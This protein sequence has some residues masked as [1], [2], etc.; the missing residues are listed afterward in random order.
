MERTGRQTNP[1]SGHP[2]WKISR[3]RAVGMNSGP[4]EF[5]SAPEAMKWVEAQWSDPANTR[6]IS[7]KSS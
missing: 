4:G 1:E 3:T 5:A 6:K 7:K 2:Q